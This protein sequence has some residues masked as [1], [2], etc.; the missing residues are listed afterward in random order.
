MD[1]LCINIIHALYAMGGIRPGYEQTV[2]TI[3][4]FPLT[5]IAIALIIPFTHSLPASH[6][7]EANNKILFTIYYE[8]N[9]YSLQTLEQTITNASRHTNGKK[10]LARSLAHSLAH[11]PCLHITT[12]QQQQHQQRVTT[13][14][15]RGGKGTTTAG[16]RG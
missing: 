9:G 13:N 4:S 8:Q 2:A 7:L 6:R 3:I 1:L 12:R 16:T 10:A 5:A 15:A 14:K 11:S